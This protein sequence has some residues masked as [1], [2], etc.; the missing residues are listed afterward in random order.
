[1]CFAVAQEE[2]IFVEAGPIV[3]E[4][5]VKYPDLFLSIGG[6]MLFHSDNDLARKSYSNEPTFSI[7]LSKHLIEGLYL[8]LSTEFSKTTVQQG[9]QEL[10]ID[11]NDNFE[12]R[13]RTISSTFTY[14]S[15][16]LG[17]NYY[18]RK[19]REFSN[20]WFI[21]FGLGN[22]LFYGKNSSEFDRFS[23]LAK[24]GRVTDATFLTGKLSFEASFMI[25]EDI[26]VLDNPYD[27]Y[28]PQVDN[29][30]YTTFKLGASLLFD[31]S[32]L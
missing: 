13:N 19:Q 6:G 11:E 8:N 12:F 15:Y 2:S 22:N 32:D 14:F 29:V 23:L 31:L 20:P 10:R 21:S 30:M 26:G 27:I 4:T 5:A 18:S 7:D 9:V 24:V 17:I 1:M 16:F 3:D 25:F 28:A